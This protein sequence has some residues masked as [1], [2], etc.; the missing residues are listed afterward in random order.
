MVLK[1]IIWVDFDILEN[2]M[3]DVFKKIGVSEEDAKICA[4][5]IIFS[6]K[7]GIDCHGIA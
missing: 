6:N 1:D 5:I 2:F 4:D 3:L 7:R